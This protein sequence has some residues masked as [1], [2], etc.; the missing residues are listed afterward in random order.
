[1][2]GETVKFIYEISFKQTVCFNVKLRLYE[3]AV[4]TENKNVESLNIF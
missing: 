3:I 1:M 2:H 4:N